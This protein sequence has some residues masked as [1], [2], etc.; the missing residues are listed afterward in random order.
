M[1]CE[2]QTITADCSFVVA[3]CSGYVSNALSISTRYGWLKIE[4]NFHLVHKGR[5]SL[6]PNTNKTNESS[7]YHTTDSNGQSISCVRNFLGVQNNKIMYGKTLVN[8]LWRDGDRVRERDRVKR[9]NTFFITLIL[10]IWLIN[11]FGMFAKYVV[12]FVYF[13]NDFIH[14]TKSMNILFYKERTHT[15]IWLHRLIECMKYRRV[16]YI[17]QKMTNNCR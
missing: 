11:V 1:V 9:K 5:C 8:R 12:Y 15:D 6:S 7:C 10:T 14:C 4:K 2:R 16:I 17:K 3:Q 13:F